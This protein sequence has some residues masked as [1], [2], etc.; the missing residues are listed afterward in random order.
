MWRRP[1]AVGPMAEPAVE[2]RR[3]DRVESV[4]R[5]DGAVVDSSGQLVAWFGDPDR[6]AYWRSAAKPLQALEV[7]LSGAAEQF[8]LAAEDLALIAGSHSGEAFHAERV[9]ALLK[10]AELGEDA[11]VLA[12]TW[13]RRPDAAEARR[14][15]GGG[16]SRLTHQCSGK[17]AGMLLAARARGWPTAGYADPDHPVQRAI[18]DRVARWSG[19][20]FGGA[21]HWAPDGC[22][23]PTFYGSLRQMAWAYAR[24]GD[25][26]GLE[27]AEA[28]AGMVVGEAMRRHPEWVSGT[29]R[30]EVALASVLE[31][32]ILAKEGA[33][34]LFC[35]ALPERGLGL[36]IKIEDGN[37]RAV[38]PVVAA[39]L[40]LLGGLSEDK[41]R[42]LTHWAHAE[43][44][45]PQGQVVG[46]IVPVFTLK[47][48]KEWGINVKP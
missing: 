3:G 36:A 9:A 6:E 11:L 28:A 5:A 48:T 32:R 37:P 2:F 45:N 19:L 31:H 46:E 25:P 7:V 12:P 40:V 24:L 35:A 47:W 20:K 13:P 30:L 22:G 29:D 15:A 27:D 8:G 18:R 42:V 43:R 38:R 41:L 14:A 39:L 23:V 44:T 16:P 4:A 33:E 21:L 17:H 10:R 34:A 26:R 1:Y